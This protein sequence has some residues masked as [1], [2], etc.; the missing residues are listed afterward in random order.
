MMKRRSR[1]SIATLPRLGLAAFGLLACLAT[2]Q[3]RGATSPPTITKGVLTVAYR[4]DDKPV[5]FIQNGKPTGFAVEFERAIAARLHLRLKFIATSFASMLPGVKN[6][7]YDTSAFATLVTP[8]RKK[9]VDFTKPVGYGQARLV[10]PVKA[11][12]AKVQDAAGKTIAITQGSALIPMLRRIAPGV[13]I[14]EF[15]NIT[16][17]LNSLLAGQV[18]GLF[19]GLATSARLVKQHPSLTMSQ[20]VTTGVAAYPVS[21]S[22]PKLRMALDKAIT[23]LME[24]GTFTRLFVKWNPP[25]IQ[26]PAELYADYPGMPHQKPVKD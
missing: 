7:R 11:P 19:T 18:N 22:N 21:K 13:R 12:I 1:L 16:S 6:R 5:S 23:A 26:I 15:P 20:T 9:M 25:G 10:I 24:N 4:T 3:A 2:P 14:R 17:S 8:Q